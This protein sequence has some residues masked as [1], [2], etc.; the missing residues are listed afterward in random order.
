MAER[1]PLARPMPGP[2]G[3]KNPNFTSYTAP[4]WPGAPGPKSPIWGKSRE[5][6]REV[7]AGAKQDLGD[8]FSWKG[9]VSGGAQGAI[10]GAAVGGP[11]GAV[12]GAVIGAGLG[13]ATTKDEKDQEPDPGY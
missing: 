3:E 13:G 8:D 9:A 12:I 2:K 10:Q 1:K 5:G 11:W 4:D 7:K 6:F